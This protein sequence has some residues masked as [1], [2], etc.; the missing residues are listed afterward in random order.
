MPL[1][2][3]LAP[4]VPGEDLQSRFRGHVQN[5]GGFFASRGKPATATPFACASGSG[6]GR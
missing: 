1:T 4:T 2:R 6:R 5:G 3:R